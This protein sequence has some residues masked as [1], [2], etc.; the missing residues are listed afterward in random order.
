MLNWVKN[1]KG[2]FKEIN[3]LKWGV[4]LYLKENQHLHI[5]SEKAG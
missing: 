4:S 2:V 5:Y 1:K 3:T